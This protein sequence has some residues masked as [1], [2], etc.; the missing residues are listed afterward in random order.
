[1]GISA[2]DKVTESLGE[3]VTS[4]NTGEIFSRSLIIPG[5]APGGYDA[6]PLPVL[7]LRRHCPPL[8]TPQSKLKRK[9]IEAL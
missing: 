3:N 7:P 4:G 9:L 8:L 1:M 5:S 6:D 2:I